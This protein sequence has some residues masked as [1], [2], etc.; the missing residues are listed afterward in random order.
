MSQIINLTETDKDG[1]FKCP[2]CG[3]LISPDDDTEKTYKILKAYYEN[4]NLIIVISCECGKM[5]NLVC[6][7]KK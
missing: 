3:N 5:V 7:V 4:T 1:N 6:E 2:K